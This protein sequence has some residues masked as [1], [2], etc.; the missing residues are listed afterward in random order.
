MAIEGQVEIPIEHL[1]YGERVR[2]FS[3]ELPPYSNNVP[4][5]LGE[6]VFASQEAEGEILFRAKFNLTGVFDPPGTASGDFYV[7]SSDHY[8]LC[9]AITLPD[10]PNYCTL[11]AGNGS[12]SPAIATFLTVDISGDRMVG[13]AGPPL[14]DENGFVIRG[15][16]PVVAT[17]LAY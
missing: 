13:Y 1:S 16:S 11:H 10:Q 7:A 5:L 4:E 9:I 17:R 2:G 6:W 3:N 14:R 12:T 15:T 8:F